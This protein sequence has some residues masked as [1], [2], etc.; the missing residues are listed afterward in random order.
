MLIDCFSFNIEINLLLSFRPIPT[1]GNTAEI[2]LTA[3]HQNFIGVDEFLGMASL[4][5]S[6]FDVY[7]RPKAKYLIELKALH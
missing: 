2:V 4:P 5:L 1:Q 7:Q 6:S 3:L